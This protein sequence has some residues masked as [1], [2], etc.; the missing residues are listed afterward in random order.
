[1][2]KIIRLTESDL[3]RIVNKVIKESNYRAKFDSQKDNYWIDDRGNHITYDPDL[4]STGYYDFDYEPYT[5][6]DN[7]EDIPEDIRD[8]L[9][10]KDIGKKFYDA[11]SRR[12]GKFQYSRKKDI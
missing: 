4:E 7:Y 5:T 2:K 12:D 1:M 9:F 10:G 11:Y 8:R 6:V 3:V